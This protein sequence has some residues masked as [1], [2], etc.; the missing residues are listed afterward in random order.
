VILLLVIL[1]VVL[2]SVASP[3]SIVLILVACVLEAVEIVMLRRWSRRLDRKTVPSTGAEAMIG[4]PAEVVAPCRPEG[5]V[6]VHG[7][8]WEAR[9]DAGADK[10][11]RVLVESVEGLTL[12][13]GRAA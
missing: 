13:V 2:A 9:C 4:E 11:E 7:E 12:V 8:L 1:V 10:G 5:T 6:H 3:W